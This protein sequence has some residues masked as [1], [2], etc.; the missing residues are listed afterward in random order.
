[1][2][3]NLNTTHGNSGGPIVDS[4]NNVI[5]ILTAGRESFNM[6]IT[7][8][9]SSQQIKTFLTKIGDKA[10]K[11]EWAKKPSPLPPFSSENLTKS[12]RGSTVLVIA[13]R[14]SD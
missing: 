5:A 13:V 12:A 7:L 3:F 4:A 9:V 11:V 6:V 8:G 14:S 1:V 2:W 10:P